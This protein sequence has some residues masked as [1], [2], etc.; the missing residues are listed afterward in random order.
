ML[1]VKVNIDGIERKFDTLANSAED[2][3]PALKR[4]GGY[5]RQR[6]LA[7]Y[8][9][10]DFPALSD[11]TV[12][13][14]A[15][16]GLKSLERKLKRDVGKQKKRAWD[17]QRDAGLA[18]RGAVMRALARLTLGDLMAQQAVAS[19]KGVRNR[20]AVLDEFNRRHRGG[21]S[22]A[23]L[24]DAQSRSL[25]AREQRAV[26]KAVG[27]PI[28]G[29]LPRTL[30]VTVARGAVTLESRTYQDFSEAHNKGLSTGHGAKMPQRTTI[31]LDSQDLDILRS[32]LVEEMLIPFTPMG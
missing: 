6:A 19:S 9:A 22:G 15:A 1:T 24:S 18:P 13:K 2:L 27:G 29:Q 14:R 23:K 17:K 12:Q 10:Q 8:A 16:R 25:N 20:Q 32:I 4:M 30:K 11:A 21:E 7:K 28:L 3:T 26:A 31:K 5:L